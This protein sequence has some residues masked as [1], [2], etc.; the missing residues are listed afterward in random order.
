MQ[1]RFRTG[2]G[3]VFLLTPQPVCVRLEISNSLL[4]KR[5]RLQM[6]GKLEARGSTTRTLAMDFGSPIWIS[7]QEVFYTGRQVFDDPDGERHTV[8][9]SFRFRKLGADWYLVGLGACVGRP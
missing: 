5:L 2:R 7:S 9:V 4:R 3:S 8:Y 1:I 6:G